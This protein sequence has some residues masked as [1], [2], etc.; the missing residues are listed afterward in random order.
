MGQWHAVAAPNEIIE[1]V[2]FPVVIE[3]T[4]IALYRLGDEIHA[5]GDICTHEHVRLSEGFVDG[6]VIEC[7]LHQS[8]FSI[9]GGRVLNPPARED[10]PSYQVRI[11]DD[12]VFVNMQTA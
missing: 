9:R 5:I 4:P 1:G 8:C 2:P 3:G 10:L 11:E 6:D 12:Q 7:P